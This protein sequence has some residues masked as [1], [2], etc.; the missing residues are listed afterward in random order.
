MVLSIRIDILSPR[1][2]ILRLG[3]RCSACSNLLTMCTSSSLMGCINDLSPTPSLQPC[4]F[5]GLIWA[6]YNHRPTPNLQWGDIPC[7]AHPWWCYN[8]PTTWL[9]LPV[10]TRHMYTSCDVWISRTRRDMTI[11]TADSCSSSKI[12]LTTYM[13]C[14][15][16]QYWSSCEFQVRTWPHLWW[17]S[18]LS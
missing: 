14:P 4:V 5:T 10:D 12:G 9:F 17:I 11:P 18:G 1:P 2:T 7:V 15:Y 16:H 13:V 6:Q 3:E 8:P